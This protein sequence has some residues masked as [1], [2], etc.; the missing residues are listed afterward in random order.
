M[1]DP[2]SRRD[3]LKTVA[4]TCIG[5]FP[6][7]AARPN[8]IKR[9]G[10]LRGSMTGAEALVETLIKEGTECVFGIPGAQNN[11]LWDTMKSKGLGYL[12]VTHEFSASC[13]ADGY[14]RSTGK[15][16]VLCT[17]PGPGITNAL[18]GVG[19]AYLDSIPLVWIVTDV[20]RGEKYHP[21]QVHE[22]PH[23]ALLQP[24]T[25]AV[26]EVNGPEEIS[27][28]ILRAFQSSQS[29]EPGPVA[30]LIPYPLLIANHAYHCPS[31]E[32]EMPAI[33]EGAFQNAIGLLANHKWRIGIYAGLGCMNCSPALVEV[34]EILQAPVAT[35][36]SGKGAMPEHHPLSVGWGYGPQGT[37][38]AEEIFK[39]IDLVLALGVRFSEVSTAY[40]SVPKTRLIH[41]DANPDNL[42]RIVPADV[43]VVA[44]AGCFLAMTNEH[45]ECIARQPN[46]RLTAQIA[47]LKRE[48]FQRNCE[49]HCKGCV[50]P[51][52]FILALRRCT[53][54]DA[55]VFVDVTATEHWSA[56][57]FQAWA[58]RTYFNP[59]DNQS[60]GWSIPAAIGAQRVHLGRQT[61]TITGDGC[62][63]MSAMEMATAAREGLPVKF[64]ILDDQQFHLMKV[65]QKPAYLRTTATVLPRL[66]YAAL[67]QGWG[68]GYH[69]IVSNQGLHAD[70]REVLSQPRPVLTCVRVEYGDRPIR[71][72]QAAKHQYTKQL[73]TAEKVHF[74]AR[75]GARAIRLTAEND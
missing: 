47:Q 5:S 66:D 54:P 52:A 71:W 53:N 18:S 48:E 51:M 29:G 65:L 7:S 43:G 28:M 33:D 62:F 6:A 61:V 41:V 58:P 27:A 38:T 4:V 8:G 22:L 46:D 70:L 50:D 26:L 17:V 1:P 32:P 59:T 44:D 63:L 13:M 45:R 55:M 21:Y 39:N 19:E 60:M 73:S 24:L 10:L 2:L 11:E 56:E 67:A 40:Y 64:F 75:M 12:L 20:A 72:V 14:A 49:I 37:R 69:E 16:G 31:L 42:G 3:L 74:L 15:P 23:R 9:D 35:S 36:V 57:A 68:V 34:A 30:V 25:K